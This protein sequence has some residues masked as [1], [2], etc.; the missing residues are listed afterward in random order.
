MTIERFKIRTSK[1]R[2]KRKKTKHFKNKEAF[3]KNKNKKDVWMDKIV[4][5]VLV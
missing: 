5:N 4:L 1:N 3:V 2:L